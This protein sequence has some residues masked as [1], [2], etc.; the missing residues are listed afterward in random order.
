MSPNPVLTKPSGRGPFPTPS[1]FVWDA[2]AD[3]LLTAPVRA[4]LDEFLSLLSQSPMTRIEIHG[5]QDPEE[6][7][8]QIIVR[9]WVSLSRGEASAYLNRVGQRVE[10]WMDTLSSDD[11][12]LFLERIA[13]Q[14]R[15]NDHAGL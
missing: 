10:A 4:L 13:F 14:L 1:A 9:Q 11:K 5:F 12:T 6:E 7:S 3:P 2:S 8:A 15:R